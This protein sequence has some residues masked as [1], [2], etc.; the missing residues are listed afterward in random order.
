MTKS[1][2]RESVVS[3]KRKALI[4]QGGWDGHQPVQVAE[5]FAGMLRNDGF[6][7]TVT[8]TFDPCKDEAMLAG[9][10]LLVPH[11]TMGKLDD[12]I[13]G[14]ICRA[15]E[16]GLGLAGCHGGMCDAFRDNTLWQWMT[17]GQFVSH[18]GNDGTKYTVT[19]TFINHEITAGIQTFE[20]SSEQYYMHVD[21]ANQVLATTLFPV[22][23]G[24]HI[25]NGP[26]QMP[27]IWTRRWGKGK[28]FYN[29]LGHNASVLSAEPVRT[30]MKRG[31]AWAAR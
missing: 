18:P 22:A 27:V 30:I 25:P 6:E 10:S 9:L 28:V 20:V 13:T 4:V 24:P 31:F 17:G 26:V 2:N 14:K 1:T 19:P 12:D 8:D 3:D 21:P 29:S 15:V 16:A 11:W 5:L 7:V 23:D